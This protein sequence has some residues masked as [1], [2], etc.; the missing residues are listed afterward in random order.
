MQR[1]RTIRTASG[2]AHKA[3]PV[4]PPPSTGEIAISSISLNGAVR[5]D[6]ARNS[7]VAARSCRNKLHALFSAATL[8][9]AS[10]SFLASVGVRG[11][12]PRAMAG[13]PL[14]ARSAA[15]LSLL[16]D[17]QGRLH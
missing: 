16:P 1:E 6:S 5:Y 14:S 11:D 17:R 7:G 10:G 15:P 8:A 2:E 12:G 13:K 9:T 4:G 3:V